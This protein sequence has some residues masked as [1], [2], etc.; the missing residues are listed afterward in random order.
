[1]FYYGNITNSYLLPNYGFVYRDNKYDQ[2]DLMLDM[3]PAALNKPQDFICNDWNRVDGIQMVHLK[4]D[5]LDH[6][7]MC[8]LRLLIQTERQF[9]GE[10]AGDDSESTN[11]SQVEILPDEE[12]DSTTALNFTK[13]TSLD[14]ERRVARLYRQMLLQILRTAEEKTTLVEDMKLLCSEELEDWKMRTAI[15]YR[16]ERKKIIH[17]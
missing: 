14:E 13:V 16:S 1:M 15:I 3:R 9:C 17:S 12:L 8:Y 4:A 5:I 11:T 2:F 7:T 6:T 10:N